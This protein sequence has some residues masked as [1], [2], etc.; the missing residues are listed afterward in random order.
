MFATHALITV[1]ILSSLEIMVF[2]LLLGGGA[3]RNAIRATAMQAVHPETG[4]IAAL[5]DGSYQVCSA[6]DPMDWQTGAGVCFV[7]DK[8][9][10]R[11]QGYYGYPHS[12]QF[13]CL[14]GRVENSLIT[15]EAFTLS[16]AGNVWESIP[17]APFAWDDEGHLTL[18]EGR[19]SPS[20]EETHEHTSLILF[21]N[22]LLDVN[23]FYQYNSPRM[24]APAQ[25]CNW[26]DL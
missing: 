19:I 22:A 7:F 4:T 12:D 3:D 24:V 11:V 25:L 6:P 14:R 10:D 16:W 8:V 23:S 9:D 21:D 5:A 26:N 20:S 2:P 1:G 17:D 13:I 15:G 18:S